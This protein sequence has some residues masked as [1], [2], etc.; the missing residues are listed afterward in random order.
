[1]L[2]THIG[3]TD[4]IITQ[5]ILRVALQNK[6]PTLQHVATI[7]KLQ[8]MEAA[9]LDLCMD[10]LDARLESRRRCASA[11]REAL[12]AMGVRA[13]G[14]P[15]DYMENAYLNVTLFDPVLR[16]TIEESLR[17]QGIG[18]GTVALAR[19]DHVLTF[20][21]RDK[22]PRSINYFMGIDCLTLARR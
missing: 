15:P 2:H 7:G 10:R 5:E 19:G 22:D 12:G 20:R 1:M 17:E 16:P 11:Y 6:M 13:V 21:C 14:P 4:A 18:F 8:G 9:Y 3:T